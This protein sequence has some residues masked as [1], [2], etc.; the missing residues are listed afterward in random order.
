V[1]ESP[2]LS[3][4]D[5]RAV[6]SLERL[7]PTA[8]SEA[9]Q[10]R[11]LL[12][13]LCRERVDLWRGMNRRID[14]EVARIERLD[15]DGMT[16][17]TRNFAP[18]TRG[19][20]FL[21]FAL[22][23]EPYFLTAPLRDDPGG[24]RLRV[25][26]PGLVYR[27]ERRSRIRRAPG[28]GDVRRVELVWDDR[29]PAEVD[30]SDL[31]PEG[32]ALRAHDAPDLHDA[33]S[34][35]VR[36]LDGVRAGSEW[37]GEIRHRAREAG[38]TRIGLDL[39]AV[40]RG[41][42]LHVE[43]RDAVIES[44]V[45]DRTRRRW[46]VA[47]AVARVA[48]DRALG[49]LG[50]RTP[51]PEVRT[52]E[53]A[54]AR[55]ERIRGLIDSW[56]DPR[57][58]CAVVIPPAWGRTKETLMPL[59]LSIVEG[60]RSAGEPIVVLR[61]DG[62][63][64]R[65][66]SHR[67]PECITPGTE[68]H[69][70]TFSQGV[71]DIATTLDFLEGEG[72]FA[73]RRVVLVSFSAASIESRRAVATDPRIHG[74]VC[75]VGAADLQSMM[76]V[77]SGGI[78]YAVGLERG[79]RYG[80]QEILGVEVDMDLA[81]LDAFA[82]DLVHLDD[83]RRDMAR[84]QVPVTWIHG[85]HDAW[86]DADR[87]RDILS[88]GDTSQ[89]RFIE[90]PTGHMLKT[91]REALETFQLVTGEVGQMALGRRIRPV[92]PDLGALDRRSRAERGRLRRGDADLRSFWRDYLVGRDGSVGYEL[93][94]HIEPYR[95][96]MEA[97][98]RALQLR[99]GDRV[100]DLGS[101]TGAFPVHLAR[102]PGRPGRLRVLEVDYVREGFQRAR[103]RLEEAPPAPHLE[104]RFAEADLDLRR[105]RA[106]LPLATESFDAALAALFLSYV[107]DP[108]AVLR[109]IQRVLRPGGRL[110]LSTLRR[111]ADMSKLYTEGLEELRVDGAQALLGAGRS[112][113]LEGLARG[114]LHQ[115]SRLL[116]LE[117]EGTFRFW[118]PQELGECVGEAG[119]VDVH[120]EWA[121]GEP[122]QAVVVTARKPAGARTA[123]G[124]GRRSGA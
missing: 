82:H 102:W 34:V 23:G 25:G 35:R 36:F 75:V 39:S 104:V 59:A 32:L 97:Q 85:R 88:R 37:H 99:E 83:S 117:E 22:D 95:Q 86:M 71:A 52:V 4:S 67:D 118:D 63:R 29:P 10:I 8:I 50:R 93:M 74:W 78:D 56:G 81:G 80:L 65:G 68:H 51:L 113:D 46:R 49:A 76:R 100:A 122:P 38:W 1:A 7:H 30:V 3:S 77:I 60:F 94:T 120:A 14:P 72:G 55:G 89:R 12:D 20:I 43:R 58:A 73:P 64:K 28:A 61:F 90:V 70:F 19:A 41:A 79:A 109:E 114:Y 119:F 69:R 11:A 103:Q 13:R 6:A 48:T 2:T 91:S 108:M 27:K 5:A 54:N 87:A 21:N 45:L 124:T 53:Y 66:E 111:D 42:S 9:S 116:D 18:G 17:R 110:V 105:G 31:S 33:G 123:R 57:G 112:A 44:S 16:L 96:L 26:L 40:A 121:L 98:V 84:I 15:A 92:L 24:G 106:A 115:A 107:A 62:V 101:G 47:S